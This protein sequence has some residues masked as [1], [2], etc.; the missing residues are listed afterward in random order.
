M[1]SEKELALLIVSH[2]TRDM[3]V[4][5]I[6]SI[7]EETTGIDYEI[8]VIDNASRDGSVESIRKEFPTV[9]LIDSEKNLGFAAAN[10]VA[11][12]EAAGTFLMLLNPD[13]LVQDGA[14]AKIYRFA[15][16]NPD[17][18]IIGGKVVDVNG[19]VDRN[20]C[21]H[22]STPWTML[23]AAS[24]LAAL[25]RRSGFF[26]LEHYGSWDRESVRRVD[27]LS[28]CFILIARD[29]WSAL[30]GFDESY[31]MYGEDTDLCLRAKKMGSHCLYTP[32]AVITHFGGAS[33]TT[34]ENTMV[35]LL[36]AAATSMRKHW[37]RLSIR[38]GLAMLWLMALRQ[39]MTIYLRNLTPGTDRSAELMEWKKIWRRRKEWLA[40]YRS[41]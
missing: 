1:L 4:D 22:R 13:T 34:K 7:Q 16:E 10:N 19:T 3:T 27:I 14:V 36:S 41:T 11:A 35:L 9:K 29:L 23:C 33:E 32:D 37:G 6:R 31:Y 12:K 28:G 25:F 17:A 8:I 38:F 40:G 18:G 26:N 39:Y 21:R 15:R 24:G 30:E 5:C 2:N 20:F